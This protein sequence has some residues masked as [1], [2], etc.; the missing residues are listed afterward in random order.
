MRPHISEELCEKCGEC[1]DTCPYE[2]FAEL[3]C[4]VV[5]ASPEDC[6]ECTACVD[7]CPHQAISMGD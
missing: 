7:S 4:A 1:V 2:V 3:D 5:V 6:I